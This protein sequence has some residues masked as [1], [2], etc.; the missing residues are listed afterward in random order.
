MNSHSNQM[1]LL[2]V[3]DPVLHPEALHVAAATGRQVV[4]STDPVDVLRHRHR[5]S[6]VLVDTATA[7]SL[8]PAA[9]DNSTG[10]AS[11]GQ[12]RGRIFL[13]GADPG[14][15]D[16]KL[17]MQI[18][19]DQAFLLPAQTAELLAALG[20][21]DTPVESRDQ[22]VGTTIGVLGAVGGVGAST[23]A[24]VLAKMLAK[25]NGHRRGTVLL[26]AVPCS[27]G[28]DLLLGIEDTRGARWPDL[29]FRRGSI[30]VPDVLAALPATA[31]GIRVLSTAR[32][33][34]ADTAVLDGAELAAALD[35]LRAADPP[36]DLI[37]DLHPGEL[38]D[39]ALDHLDHLVLLIPAEVRA[40]AAAV[41]RR[42]DPRLHRVPLSVVLRHRGWSGLDAAEV[43]EILGAEV[44][45]ELG[46]VSRLARN[47]EMRGLDGAP[48]RSLATVAEAVLADL[49][50]TAESVGSAG[51][52]R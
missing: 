13:L 7:R 8:L 21:Q 11:G 43:E 24:V 2:A 23:L 22:G 19:A 18:H 48:P 51:G 46:S 16:W 52:R 14:P 10:T 38:L 6:A 50:D 35:C 44:T 12:G 9:A 36:L 37:V 26:D 34:V 49:G 33:T 5:V 45:A 41:A 47:T 17:A 15:T 28:I 29:G 39:A 30:H 3:E 40:V 31:E 27:G 1:I 20:R 32:S 4:E 42:L 25:R